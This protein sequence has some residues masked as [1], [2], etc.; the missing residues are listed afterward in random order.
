M[1]KQT[2]ISKKIEKSIQHLINRCNYWSSKRP[3]CCANCEFVGL[4]P[5]LCYFLDGLRS[6]NKE[7]LIKK[8]ADFIG[9]DIK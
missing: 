8:I 6:S 9:E 5:E 7:V 4:G 2:V 3:K 1:K